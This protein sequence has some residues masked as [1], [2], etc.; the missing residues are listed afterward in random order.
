L[1]QLAFLNIARCGFG[2]SLNYAEDSNVDEHHKTTSDMTVER[3]FGV[4]SE[5]M[6]QRL[7]IPAWLYKLPI[8]QFSIE[9][10]Y[11]FICRF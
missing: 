1:L 10:I 6:V 2:L 8:K 7:A 3:G 9:I 4:I 11:T 5:T